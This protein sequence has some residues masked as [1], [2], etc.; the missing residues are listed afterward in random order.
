MIECLPSGGWFSLGLRPRENHPPF[1][2]TFHHVTPTGMAYLYNIKS[3]WLEKEHW[4]SNIRIVEYYK[5]KY[6]KIFG[7]R[8]LNLE[9]NSI[10]LA[11]KKSNLQ[12]SIKSKNSML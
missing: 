9:V 2:E 1:G 12:M 11:V 4:I 7:E 10:I 6:K 8:E 5:I 3:F